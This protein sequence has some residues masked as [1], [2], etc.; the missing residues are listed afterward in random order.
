MANDDNELIPAQCNYPGCGRV[1]MVPRV[2][3]A[4][5]LGWWWCE[6]S[7]VDPRYKDGLYCEEH[8]AKINKLIEES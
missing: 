6:P 3:F 2:F 1:V 5:P 8:G 4:P 7:G